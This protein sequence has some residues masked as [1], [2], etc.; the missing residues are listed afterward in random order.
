MTDTLTIKKPKKTKASPV[1]IPITCLYMMK[2]NN[3]VVQLREWGVA[4]W[5]VQREFALDS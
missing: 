4:I 3:F 1:R 2:L 5:A